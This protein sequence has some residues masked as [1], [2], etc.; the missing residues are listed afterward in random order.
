MLVRVFLCTFAYRIKNDD[1]AILDL[2][3]KGKR[4]KVEGFFKSETYQKDGKDHH[5]IKL[6]ATGISEVEK[7]KK[8]EAA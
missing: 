3:K 2:L 7:Q 6:I 4:V 1:Q 8:E 5:V